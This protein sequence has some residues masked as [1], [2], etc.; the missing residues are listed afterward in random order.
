[1]KISIALTLLA[2][3]T[4]SPVIWAQN[5]ETATGEIKRIKL[6]AGIYTTKELH[7]AAVLYSDN[8]WSEN[9]TG[10][11]AA[12]LSF[13][14]YRKIEVALTFAYQNVKQDYRLINYAGPGTRTVDGNAHYLSF[15]PEIRFNWIRTSDDLF[16]FYSSINVG[17]SSVI[18]DVEGSDETRIIP[19]SHFNFVG[20]RFGNELGF[21]FETGFGN[22]GFLNFGI[23]YRFF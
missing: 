10:S 11:Y 5:S 9:V 23:D 17:L 20:L 18:V 22:R 8:P 4:F 13:F 7:S 12:S 21:L 2:C 19:S 1:M 15:M 16:E 6:S 14:D 3:L